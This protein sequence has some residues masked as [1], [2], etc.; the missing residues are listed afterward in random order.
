MKYTSWYFKAEVHSVVLFTDDE[1]NLH[2]YL[3]KL[4]ILPISW[5][6]F[7]SI[8]DTGNHVNILQII[9]LVSSQWIEWH[10]N[11]FLFACI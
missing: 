7:L 3:D 9:E 10:V 4:F 8:L 5:A 6:W 11:I 2:S 1:E